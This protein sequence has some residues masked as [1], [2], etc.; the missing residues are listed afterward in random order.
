VQ[1]CTVV[2]PFARQ[3]FKDILSDDEFSIFLVVL[4]DWTEE[5]VLYRRSCFE[6]PSHH[7]GIFH[8]AYCGVVGRLPGI[9]KLDKVHNR[10]L[11][12]RSAGRYTPLE[13]YSHSRQFALAAVASGATAKPLIASASVS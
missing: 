5:S 7:A 11:R 13:A 1:S 3:R 4:L 9:F 12:L 6:N 8:F 2:N 10:T